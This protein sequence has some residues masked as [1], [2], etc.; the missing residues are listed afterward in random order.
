MI[1]KKIFFLSLLIVPL[2]AQ[3]N[4]HSMLPFS[5]GPGPLFSFG[6][7]V[8]PKNVLVYRQIYTMTERDLTTTLLQHN[9][10]YY[11]L[12]D[13]FTLVIKQPVLL[14]QRVNGE[15]ARGLANVRIEIETIPYVYEVPNEFRF[16]LTTVT[17]IIPPTTTVKQITLQTLKSTNFFIFATQS[18]TTTKYF[19]YSGI[20]AFIPTTHKGLN[21]GATLYYETGLCRAVINT[22]S[23]FLGLTFEI[24]G[25][26]K[27]PRSQ[28]GVTDFTTGSNMIYYGPTIRVSTAH[29]IGQIGIQY[30]WVRHLK[31]PTD[32]PINYR[33]AMAGAFRYAF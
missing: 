18:N 7:N 26:Y 23:F 10:L 1:L 30:P 31:Q 12:S 22:N 11:G 29:F 3:T 15:H 6:L 24:S 2:V 4:R 8:Q 16:R 5:S 20:G 21:F 13:H 14:K 33:F 17:G 9:H 19:Q 32:N 27:L 25:E 28:D